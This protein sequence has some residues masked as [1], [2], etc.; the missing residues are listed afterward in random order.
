M[1]P[2]SIQCG[3]AV[4]LR[5]ARQAKGLTVRKVTSQ[6]GVVCIP[7]I[8]SGQHECNLRTLIR[9]AS[10]YGRLPSDLLREAERHTAWQ[11]LE[12]FT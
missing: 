4:A 8:E 7:R 2:A 3:L 10:C 12:M 6:T 9:L 11:Q 5:R 1:T